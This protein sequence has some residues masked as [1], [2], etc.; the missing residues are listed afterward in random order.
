MA[1]EPSAKAGGEALLRTSD[2]LR[3][4]VDSMDMRGSELLQQKLH[5]CPSSTT[6]VQDAEV[7]NRSTQLSEKRAFVESLH[8]SAC[9]IVYQ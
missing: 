7:F 1:R 9:A 6:Y 2:L 4:Q 3:V 5:S 8:K